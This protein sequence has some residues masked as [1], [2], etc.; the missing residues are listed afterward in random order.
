MAYT[1]ESI[2]VG[3]F[4]QN[5]HVNTILNAI[6]NEVTRWQKELTI[7]D[8]ITGNTVVYAST[9][10]SV[11]DYLSNWGSY[12]V[13]APVVGNLIVTTTLLNL[14]TAVD[15][16]NNTCVCYCNYSCTCN[17]DYSCT[18]RCYYLCTC[19]CA[20][21]CSCNCNYG[22]SGCSCNVYILCTCQCNYR[23]GIACS[24]N[25]H[26]YCKC[27]VQ[28][29]GTGGSGST[30]CGSHSATGL[31]PSHATYAC[32]AYGTAQSQDWPCSCNCHYTP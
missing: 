16:I 5:E 31:C 9:L 12:S 1:W 14:R 23:A 7:M 27:N 26:A 20:H 29:G 8:D 15:T 22:A 4:V 3:A 19:Q 13:T 6:R 21:S 25:N 18:C 28:Y 32:S 30:V 11:R 24:C 10:N 17:C 2:S